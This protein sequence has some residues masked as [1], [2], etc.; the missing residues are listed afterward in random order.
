MLGRWL[1]I[2]LLKFVSLMSRL[3]VVIR[4]FRWMRRNG[5]CRVNVLWRGMVR[6]STFVC[7]LVAMGLTWNGSGLPRRIWM[8]TLVRKVIWDRWSG[9]RI[10]V[11]GL[12]F[13]RLVILIDGKGDRGGERSSRLLEMI[14]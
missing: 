1:F 3:G 7:L 11:I 4:L 10:G 9:R 2:R 6:D 14:I 8:C 13:G 12:L 5:M